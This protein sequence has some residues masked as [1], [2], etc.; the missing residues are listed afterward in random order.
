MTLPKLKEVASQ[1]GIDGAAKL[2]KDDLVTAIAD[3][4]A[5]VKHAAKLAMPRRATAI[6]IRIQIT[7]PMM[8]MMKKIHQITVHHQIATAM[9][10]MTVVDVTVDAIAT[11]DATAEA[12]IVETA[13]SANQ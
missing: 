3:L 8:A 9:I 7:H 1:L 5:S 12:V 2:K 10:A 13:K 6:Q 4:Q 11:V